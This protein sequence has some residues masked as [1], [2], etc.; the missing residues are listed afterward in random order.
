MV[1]Q[2]CADLACQ[3]VVHHLGEMPGLVDTILNEVERLGYTRKQRLG[4]RMALEE[5]LV[6]AVK[7]GNRGDTNKAV[8]VR[9]QISETQFAVEIEDEGEGFQPEC[10][11]D[12]SEP[13]NLARP[14]GRGVLLIKHYMTWVQYSEK[15]NCVTMCLMRG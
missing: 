2:L 4:I 1:N 10:L 5:A 6:N 8:Q 14:S 15:G 7:H 12:P 13:E 3:C 9:Y 11:P